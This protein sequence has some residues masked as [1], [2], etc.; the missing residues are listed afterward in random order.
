MTESQARELVEKCPKFLDWQIKPE[1]VAELL[2]SETAKARHQA[3]TEAA[4]VLKR[5]F[6]YVD[7]HIKAILQARD[8]Q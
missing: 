8:T 1:H 7:L 5:D 3:F 2:V 4:N 6:A